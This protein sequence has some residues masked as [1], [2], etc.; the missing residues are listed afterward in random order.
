MTY[1][2]LDFVILPPKYLP[3]LKRMDPGNMNTPGFLDDVSIDSIAECE[4]YSRKY[5]H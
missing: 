1:F 5:R 4:R 3:D 2:G